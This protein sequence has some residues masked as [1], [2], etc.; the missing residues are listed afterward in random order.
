M[1]TT[2]TSKWHECGL[3]S[4]FMSIKTHCFDTRMV[5]CVIL[6]LSRLLSIS[7]HLKNNS[8][9]FMQWTW[10]DAVRFDTFF[11]CLSQQICFVVLPLTKHSG[12]SSRTYWGTEE[13]L[14]GG[15]TGGLYETTKQK[16]SSTTRIL[17]IFPCN[18]LKLYE[19][20]S[21]APNQEQVWE[22]TQ[23]NNKKWPI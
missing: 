5:V 13:S 12:Q 10:S 6:T 22:K 11:L 9:Q 18:N 1:Y 21:N 4:Q 7:G 16:S 19:D 3:C 2:R 23:E 20:N 15:A 14:T 17:S 8:T